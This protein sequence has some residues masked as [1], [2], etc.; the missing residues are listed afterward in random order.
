MLTALLWNLLVTSA[1]AIALAGV[2]RLA[3]MRRRPAVRH[4]LW[5]LLLAKMVTPP[6]IPVP[7]L[8]ASEHGDEAVDEAVAAIAANES[9]EVRQSPL[10]HRARP[11]APDPGASSKLIDGPETRVTDQVDSVDL[12]PVTW[13]PFDRVLLFCSLVGTLVLIS[14]HGVRCATFRRWLTRAG[15]DNLALAQCC[16]EVAASL[17]IRGTVR[18]RVVNARAAPMLWGCW[19]PVVVIPRQLIDDLSPEQLR[20]IVAHEMAHFARRDPWSNLFA[21]L[22]KT[23]MWWNPI[24]WWAHRE[25]R[26]AQELCCDAIAI[27]VASR[28]CY[29]TTLLKAVDFVQAEQFAHCE[30]ALEMGARHSILRRF[31][32]IADTKLSHRMS[33]RWMLLLAVSIAPLLCIPVRGQEARPPAA[34]QRAPDDAEGR[35]LTA[36]DQPDSVVLVGIVFARVSP[37]DEKQLTAWINDRARAKRTVV[38]KGSVFRVGRT[39]ATVKELRKDVV[40]VK[41]NDKV[42]TWK[43]GENF[44]ALLKDEKKSAERAAT[45]ESAKNAPNENRGRDAAQRFK[46]QLEVIGDQLLIRGED[47]DVKKVTEL[48]RRLEKG[49]I[50]PPRAAE[51]DERLPSL[52]TYLLDELDPDVVRDVAQTLLAAHPDARL[53][54]DEKSGRLIVLGRR[55]DHA[56]VRSMLE[57]LRGN[58]GDDAAKRKQDLP[59]IDDDGKLRFAFNKQPWSDALEW[60]AKHA[61]L[62]LLVEDPIPGTFTFRDTKAYT[63]AESLD[64]FNAVLVARGYA[65]LRRDRFLMV[66]NIE[67]GIP[68]ELAPRVEISELDKRGKFEF[69]SVMFPLGGRDAEK[70]RDEIL[71]L[72]SKGARVAILPQTRKLL[73][74]ERAGVMRSIR[75]VIESIDDPQR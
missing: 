28:N 18:G 29:A 21:F 72:L 35:V 55:D 10:E 58:I 43:L 11:G 59:A 37:Q 33:R 12:A 7:L 22:V 68:S 16:A 39:S 2:C 38:H 13:P 61:G 50:K 32:M 47:E 1:L 46:V 36:G 49:K 60:Y 17:G 14:V 66:V 24:A 64:L 9:P 23:L 34:A 3:W 4:T 70:T 73:V 52:Q 5:L 53:T 45:E 44:A 15:A 31:E 25:V 26:A 20:S 54:V 62:S 6:L 65:L 75:K 69:V 48:L 63:V 71:P 19:R 74:T 40:V 30:L 57:R 42:R 8:P 41:L 51:D 27:D 67:D 56:L